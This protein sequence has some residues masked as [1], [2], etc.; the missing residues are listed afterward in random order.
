MARKNKKHLN[1]T[2]T[3]VFDNFEPEIDITD[4]VVPDRKKKAS[5]RASLGVSPATATFLI[6][7][8]GGIINGQTFVLT[9]FQG[10]ATT[11]TING[12]VAPSAGG[13]SGGTATVGFNGVGGGAAGKIAAAN[14]ISIAI[15]A[16]TDAT[17]VAVSD[18]VDTVTVTQDTAGILGNRALTS[19]LSGVT[20][21]GFS[22]GLSNEFNG[23]QI[24]PFSAFNVTVNGGYN[25][26]LAASGLANVDITNLHHD[27]VVPGPLIHNH[28]LQG[29]F[30][31][32]FVGGRQARHVAP[33][34]TASRKEEYTI[35]ITSGTGTIAPVIKGDIPTG[36]Y[37]RGLAAKRPVNLQNIKTEVTGHATNLGVR[38]IGNYQHNYE[39][40]QGSSRLQT[41]IDFIF[42]NSNFAYN[43]PTAF[44]TSIPM[45][46]N[47]R[48][49]SAD[50]PAPRQRAGRRINKSIIVNTFAAPGSKL[51]SKQLFR[52]VNS[53]QLSPNNAL[54]FRNVPVRQTYRDRLT[55][56][57]TLGGYELN[58]PTVP[59]V[60]KTP[61][62]LTERLEIVGVT[63]F[64]TG[65]VRD[66]GY[67]TRPIPAGDSTQWFFSMSGSNTPLYSEYVLSGNRYP[68][69]VPVPVTTFDTP[70]AFGGA[71][72]SDTAGKSRFIW[73]ATP[74]VSPWTQLREASSNQGSYF[75]RKNIY[76][77]EPVEQ[78][79]VRIPSPPSEMRNSG[80][81][82]VRTTTDRAGNTLKYYY[83]EQYNEA[84][85]T[86][87]YKP[88][89]H[90]IVTPLGTPQRTSDNNV[91]IDMKYS[92]GNS[93]MGFAHRQ[94]NR[95]IQGNLKFAHGQEKRPYEILRDQRISEV[96]SYVNGVEQ[97]PAFEYSETIYPREV[98]TYLSETRQRYTFANNFWKDDTIISLAAV[99]GYPLSSYV[100]LRT[101]TVKSVYN[102]QINRVQGFFTTSQG[103]QIK[104]QDQLPYNT[105]DS[106][107]LQG[108]GYGSASIWPLDSYL[109]SD[110][111]STLVT[112]LTSSTP[113]VFADAST[114]AAGELM[115]TH[116]G[117]I[118]DQITNASARSNPGSA[119][120]QTASVNSAQYVYN[121]PVTR[122]FNSSTSATAAVASIT[123]SYAEGQG[124]TAATA[125]LVFGSAANDG[126]T[127][128]EVVQIEDTDSSR[129]M[130]FEFDNTATGTTF[131]GVMVYTIG[132]D[133]GSGGQLSPTQVRDALFSAIEDAKTTK[134]LEV[135]VAKAGSLTINLTATVLGTSMNSK[136][137]LYSDPGP[138]STQIAVTTWAGGADYTYNSKT[139]LID[140]DTHGTVT[141]AFDVGTA[142][143][144]ST[145]GIIGTAGPASAAQ[146]AAA[147]RQTINLSQG[148]GD[149]TVTAGTVVSN[150]VPLTA[151]NT[152]TGMNGKAIAGTA[153]ADGGIVAVDFAGGAAATSTTVYL[154]E[155]RSPGSAYTRPPW[156]AGSFRMHID[157]PSKGTTAGA[158]YPFYDTYEDYAKEIRLVGKDHTIVPE[159]R[160]SEHVSKYQASGPLVAAVSASLEITGA[161]ATNNSGLNT[162]FYD[163]F[164]MTDNIEFL[165][166]LM[167]QDTENRNYIFNN[168]PRHF[169]LSSNAI[170]K[171]LPYNGF[172]PVNRT[173]DIAKSFYDSY[174]S[175]AV[176]EGDASAKPQAWRSVYK[177]FFA[178]GIMYNS[179]KSGLSVNYPVRRATRNEGQYLPVSATIPLHGALSGTLS[180]AITPAGNIPGNKR[181]PTSE[182]NWANTDVNKMFWADKLPFESLMD[183][184]SFLEHGFDQPVIL[185]D[186]NEFL[187]HDV[188]GSIS[189]KDVDD[190][191]Y[192][193]MVSNFLANV[194]RFFL[195]EKSHKFADPGYLT[196]FVSQF[197]SPPKNSQQ[198]TAPARTVQVDNKS[199]YMME[200]GL[201]KTDNFNLYSNP[202]AFGIPTSTGSVDWNASSMTATQIPSGTHWPKHRGEFAPFTPPY[203]YGPSLVRLLFVP[204]QHRT[205]Y[206]LEQIINNDEGE[207]YVQYLNESGSYYDVTSGSYVDRDG[208]NVSTTGTPTYGWN[209]A[210]QNRMD[211]DASI[212]IKNDFPLGAGGSYKPTDPNRWTIMPKWECPILDF[213]DRHSGKAEY[214]FSSSINV[215]QYTA[216]SNGMWHQYGI[217]PNYNEGVYMY[218]KDIPTGKDEEY[219]RVALGEAGSVTSINYHYV[220]KVPKF[221]IDS[222][223]EVK[224]LADLC[225]FDPDEI[226][227][228]GFDPSKAKRMGEL[229][230]DNEKSLSEAILALPVYED[231]KGNMRIVT[232]RAPADS[233]GPKIKE[234]RKKFTKYS[235]PPALA[236][237]LQ[238]MVPPGYPAVSELINPFGTDDYDKILRGSKITQVPVIY[239]MEHSI[240]L[241][242]QDLGDMWQ[243][244][245]PDIGRSFKKSFSAIDHYMPGDNVEET[246]TQ[247]PEVLKKQIELDVERTGHPR[248]DLLDVAIPG[249]TDGFFPEIKW[250]IFKVKERGLL[251]YSHMIMEEVDGPNALGFDNLRGFLSRSGLSEEQLETIDHMKDTFA[252]YSYLLKHGI[253]NPTYN[254]PYDYF[255]LLELA[256]VDTKVGFRPDLKE[257]YS[258]ATEEQSNRS[259]INFNLPLG[260]TSPLASQATPTLT[261]FGSSNNDD[262]T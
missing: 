138:G 142:P 86:S 258:L 39:V 196:K 104:A 60:H 32:R 124:I 69:N 79:V 21:T 164:A 234:F 212:C 195:K 92:Y 97:I 210:W 100:S 174:F 191:L 80:G 125:Q 183:P 42:N 40:I 51:D 117:S 229:G 148:V 133:N 175:R 87:R 219:D 157:G 236:E 4:V 230:E 103:F 20:A 115:M 188:S 208:N 209:R 256:K 249:T 145:S 206:T 29:P 248:Y 89:R 246:P 116:Y 131:D 27:S 10:T 47:E 44:L 98:Y 241:S 85:V 167:P 228:K 193:K 121:I 120:Y 137:V 171:F 129:V 53:D 149:I 23:Q 239:L 159:F 33:F 107:Y 11:Y 162:A 58:N 99:S 223:R 224:S 250:L 166:D 141:Y 189:T 244:I 75:I 106:S 8:S 59:S 1:I 184:V 134:D 252:K 211:I 73:G 160:I 101:P 15:N 197:G 158:V 25:A 180:P 119:V 225:G 253:K 170:A 70:P 38:R 50:Y 254:W 18:G 66:N 185:A 36:R 165:S 68:Q 213:P 177:Q 181:R 2:N 154:P 9:D 220:K 207:L 130:A 176:Y 61:S 144:A 169:E 260:S 57:M 83:S 150:T 31:K 74:E 5:F 41:N 152:G 28:P 187:F 63:T 242:R 156:S 214:D 190:S 109:F 218:I 173:L 204:S 77:I 240:T 12:G 110:W 62:N 71:I 111:K 161:N 140:D 168:Y 146:V 26:S 95:T 105:L 259:A 198:N 192:K 172:Y 243:G 203:Y 123:A 91:T 16:T 56:P 35:S 67:V 245:M 221:I 226:I 112:V 217:M 102:A 194:P 155:V 199:A 202:Y 201:L 30:T 233:L 143:G 13:G 232:L 151:D 17:Y 238:G 182:L 132:T 114:M 96:P 72:Y 76:E 37:L 139:L 128:G 153:E 147:I 237:M 55:E 231:E 65:T 257:E 163:R 93:L 251:D 108:T 179:I 22:G 24:A 46:A 82:S 222:G 64:A 52:D 88:F 118:N 84:P 136:L 122:A 126:N 227:R 262:E 48:T 14:A 215:T 78:F 6:T 34:R 127:N 43:M 261:L 7:S 45:R 81:T 255:S 205:D 94:L 90:R 235:L 3:I 113:V 216:S 178:P 54:P 247:F 200:V 19:G 135:N 49:G 186:I